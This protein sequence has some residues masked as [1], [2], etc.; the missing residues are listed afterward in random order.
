MPEVYQNQSSVEIMLAWALE[1][2][3]KFLQV[4]IL[5]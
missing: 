3:R 5:M 4:K 2:L 1:I